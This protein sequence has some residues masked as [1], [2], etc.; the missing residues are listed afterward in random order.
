MAARVEKY[1]ELSAEEKE[2]QIEGLFRDLA[3]FTA[4][5]L[6]GKLR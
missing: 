5:V 4:R 3:S 6:R 2:A 1:L